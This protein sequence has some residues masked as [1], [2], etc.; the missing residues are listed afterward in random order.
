[1]SSGGLRISD[2]P[3]RSQGPGRRPDEIVELAR[4]FGKLS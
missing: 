2:V 1:M 3:A 4:A